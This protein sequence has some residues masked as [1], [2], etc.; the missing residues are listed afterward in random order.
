[1]EGIYFSKN[2]KSWQSLHISKCSEINAKK[3]KQVSF[4]KKNKIEDV[5][6][7]SELTLLWAARPIESWDTLRISENIYLYWIAKVRGE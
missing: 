5:A 7:H 1:M 4:Y 3:K 6:L 2:S